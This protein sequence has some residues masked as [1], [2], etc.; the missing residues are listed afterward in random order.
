MF[1]NGA[2]SVLQPEIDKKNVI[3]PSGQ[4]TFQQVN[5]ADWDPKN[6]QTRMSNLITSTYAGGTELDGVLSP[7]DTL[8]RSMSYQRDIAGNVT[9]SSDGTATTTATTITST[10]KPSGRM[11][12]S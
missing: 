4:T 10:I 1:Y 11:F 3:V 9:Q 5:T 6:S 2:M 12:C 7:N 8:G